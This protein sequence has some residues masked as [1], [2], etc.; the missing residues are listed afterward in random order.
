MEK[1]RT[2]DC[3]MNTL[4]A[5]EDDWVHMEFKFLYSDQLSTLSKNQKKS[6]VA[7]GDSLI[8]LYPQM[9][10]MMYDIFNRFNS[11][12]FEI[13]PFLENFLC[14]C[15]C[16]AC[17]DAATH[18]ISFRSEECINRNCLFFFFLEELF[19]ALQT[20][21]QGL[22]PPLCRKDKEFEVK[23]FRDMLEYRR[24]KFPNYFIFWGV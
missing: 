4:L 8:Q 3:N 5:L 20:C 18:T 10:K 11:I 22:Y 24:L 12:K 6:S 16:V 14:V 9:K 19:H 13:D 15:V 17:Y 7:S 2:R 21:W 1:N 23:V